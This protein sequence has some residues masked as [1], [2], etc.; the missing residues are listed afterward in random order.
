MNLSALT[1]PPPQCSDGTKTSRMTANGGTLF[2]TYP[3]FKFPL[4]MP[5]DDSTTWTGVEMLLDTPWFVCTYL[6]REEHVSRSFLLTDQEA[7]VQMARRGIAAPV[8]SIHL[9]LPPAH[10][11]S[12]DWEIVPVA[13]LQTV[14]TG[15]TRRRAQAVLTTRD[16]TRYAGFPL[17]PTDEPMGPLTTVAQ[18]AL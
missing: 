11:K 18:F 16:G 7:L 6:E 15:D 4:Q 13:T 12:K 5:G 1:R 14:G 8:E 3:V 9:V 10:S 17:E 2:A